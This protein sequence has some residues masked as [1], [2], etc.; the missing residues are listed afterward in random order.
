MISSFLF[1]N[2]CIILVACGRVFPAI[3]RHASPKN[4]KI[5]ENFVSGNCQNFSLRLGTTSR[6]VKLDL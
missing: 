3:K 2:W 5:S 4:E 6:R 1:Y